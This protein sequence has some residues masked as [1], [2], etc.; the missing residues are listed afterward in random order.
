MPNALNNLAW[1]LASHSDTAI[2][3]GEEAVRLAEQACEL[4]GYRTAILLGTLGA[5]F[6]EAGRFDDAVAAAQKAE[7]LATAAGDPILAEK[8][9]T[10][11]E[12]FRSRR[13]FH[14]LPESD[15]TM[16]AQQN[17]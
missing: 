13:P 10:L 17:D 7:A 12:L 5:A 16:P 11:A 9:R 3:N 14:E 15:G 8:N 2:R 4:T 6:A 1:I